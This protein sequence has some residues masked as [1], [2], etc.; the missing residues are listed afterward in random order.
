M[1][2]K[3]NDQMLKIK[4]KRSRERR[5]AILIAATEVLGEKGVHAAT[6]TDISKAAKL[7]LSSIYDYFAN[8]SDLLV[9]VPQANFDEL[10]NKIDQALEPLESPLEKLR[11]FYGLTFSYVETNPKWARFFYL[12]VWPSVLTEEKPIRMAVNEYAQR[13][14]A[15]IEE[16]IASK[17]ISQHHDAHLL[18][19][20]LL[21]G[22]TQSVAVWLLYDR[23][24]P[25][26]ERGEQILNLVLAAS[27]TT[28]EPTLL[29]S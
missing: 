9:A 16:G 13:L 2:A 26:S 10:Y 27:A 7:P 20:I 24:Y 17:Q 23:P 19:S 8:K 3:G 29:P 4:Q 14:I 11:T 22:L 6:L 1:S 12:E 28:S 15:I 5:Q 18:A 25:L 21:G